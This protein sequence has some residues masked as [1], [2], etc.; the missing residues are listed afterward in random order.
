MAWGS[1][2]QEREFEKRHILGQEERYL[3]TD[4]LTRIDYDT[5]YR[6]KLELME[7]FLRGHTG[8]PILDVG[9]NT[10]GEAEVLASRGHR[11]VATDI[12]E[13]AL[14]LSKRRAHAFGRT[15]PAYFAGDAH[16]LPFVAESFGS[17]I[18]F[19]VLHHF[20]D[21]DTVLAELARLL[22]PGGRLFTYE[23][24]ALNPYRR[25]AELR[26]VLMGSIER[27]FTVGGL[28]RRLRSAGFEIDAISR[29]VLPPSEWKKQN[30]TRLRATLKDLYYAVGRRML[31]VFGNI[32]VVA[33][34]PGDARPPTE[35]TDIYDLLQC[36]VTGRRLV[37]ER[38]S[39]V[40]EGGGPGL[41]YPVVGGIPVLIPEDAE[42][43]E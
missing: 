42:S 6:E 17:I 9:A 3:A 20:E 8:G 25:V 10:A 33:R 36:P 16:R 31:P 39:F 13:I 12:N 23:P 19:E 26:F 5:G 37:K 1:R 7:E 4:V 11:M 28:Q 35:E 29:S 18:A 15:G 41:R 40:P 27:S 43:V 21:L 38:C 32:V 2:E 14:G 24:F 22:R 30:A 34:K